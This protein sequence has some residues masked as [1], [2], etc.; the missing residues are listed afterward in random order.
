MKKTILSMLLAVI[1]VGL[2]AVFTSCSSDDDDKNNNSSQI[3]PIVIETYQLASYDITDTPTPLYAR[4][5]VYE[6]NNIE[7]RD[8]EQDNVAYDKKT[9]K[10]VHPKYYADRDLSLM[11]DVENGKT[12]FVF[13]KIMDSYS[14]CNKSYS[15]CTITPIYKE[16]EWQRY[17]KIFSYNAV[18]EKYEEWDADLTLQRVNDFYVGKF[19]DSK[20][21]IKSREKHSLVQET[22]SS[23][24]Y[25]INVKEN[26]RYEFDSNGFYMGEAIGTYTTPNVVNGGGILLG[27]LGVVDKMKKKFGEP[28]YYSE[29]IYKYEAASE[30]FK[31]IGENVAKGGSITYIF[32]NGKARAYI[33]GDYNYYFANG[34]SK[35]TITETYNK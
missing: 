18:S 32:N 24:E 9:G 29:N 19:G 15:Y 34:G 21:Y 35:W 12:Y 33:I 7:K 26:I 23:L 4:I 3:F 31:K 2:S 17:K 10:A 8:I 16:N 13:V 22:S 27:Y 1:A 14:F 25:K 20:E 6:G 11:C 28:T 5:E 30:D